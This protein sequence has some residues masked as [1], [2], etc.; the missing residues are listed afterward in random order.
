MVRQIPAPH[1]EVQSILEFLVRLVAASRRSHRREPAYSL[2]RQPQW[3]R[4]H[5]LRADFRS[6]GAYHWIHNCQGEVYASPTRM[7]GHTK[8]REA[9]LPRLSTP[10][11]AIS[12]P[13]SSYPARPVSWLG[14]WY[15][16]RD[17]L[18]VLSPNRPG[19][20]I[21]GVRHAAST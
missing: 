3:H 12:L 4:N 5:R 17:H 18:E 9:C 6:K 20:G 15:A 11:E 19:V 7:C 1:Q 10:A 2:A 21:V 16:L 8:T 13:I 14:S